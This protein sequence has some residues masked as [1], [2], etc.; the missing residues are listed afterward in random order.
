MQ[1]QR[2]FEATKS[3]EQRPARLNQSPLF[4]GNSI[5]LRFRSLPQLPPEEGD[6]LRSGAGVVRTEGR[7]VCA[8]RDAIFYCPQNGLVTVIV[9]LY[10]GER[11]SCRS[12]F[13]RTHGTPE[14][15]HGLRSGAGIIGGKQRGGLAL[16]YAIFQSP[17]DS[18]VIMRAALYIGERIDLIGYFRTSSGFPEKCRNF[19]AGTDIAGAKV[20][21]LVPSVIP[22]LIAQKTAL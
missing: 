12:R 17:A 9:R 1:V 8:L 13:G 14:E 5:R 19:C 18:V 20:T 11:A 7:D 22:A 6:D 16:C 15:G 4:Q 3:K 2:R 10:V 21:S